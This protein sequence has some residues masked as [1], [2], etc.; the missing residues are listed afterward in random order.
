MAKKAWIRLVTEGGAVLNFTLPKLIF[1]AIS[2]TTYLFHYP[3]ADLVEVQLLDTSAF[4]SEHM[5]KAIENI[6][7]QGVIVLAK[8]GRIS[9][10]IEMV[11]D[12]EGCVL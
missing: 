4:G 12:S 3:G 10:V 2:D 8:P 6:K 7:A 5:E 1:D 11:R 9:S